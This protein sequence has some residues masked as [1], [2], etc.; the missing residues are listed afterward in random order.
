M[1]TAPGLHTGDTGNVAKTGMRDTVVREPFG[2][3]C[4]EQELPSILL[5]V[6]ILRQHRNSRFSMARGPV[7]RFFTPVDYTLCLF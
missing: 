5:P 2:H 1:G 7:N 3:F 4:V 6:S